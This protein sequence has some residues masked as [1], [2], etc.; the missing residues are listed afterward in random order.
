MQI[1]RL[2]DK[3]YIDV[4]KTN[5]FENCLFKKVS[6]KFLVKTKLIKLTSRQIRRIA[7]LFGYKVIN[8]KR[9]NIFDISLGNLNEDEKKLIKTSKFKILQ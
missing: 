5:P 7:G 6:F 1:K 9:I 3:I 8:S 4:K 2:I